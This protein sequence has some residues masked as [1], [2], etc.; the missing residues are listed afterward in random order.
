M[1]RVVVLVFFGEPDASV[2]HAKE[3]GPSMAVPLLALALP[4]LLAGYFG[5][6]LAGLW[7]ERYRFHV[8]WGGAAATLAALLGFVAAYWLYGK[9]RVPSM[10]R[11][12]LKPA[13]AFIE[14]SAVD[15]LYA[16]LYR[17]GLLGVAAAAAWTDRYIVDGA[18]NAFGSAFLAA[19][20]RLRAVQTG[21]VQD[22][23]FAVAA[24]VVALVM[25]GVTR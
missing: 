4:S 14:A 24:G 17:R 21:Y 20:R 12:L 11:A 10:L 23:L 8:G 1:G 6:E 16:A 22:Y 13:A 25:W 15:R 9:Q 5:S 18:I 19:S 3:S 7:G 2:E